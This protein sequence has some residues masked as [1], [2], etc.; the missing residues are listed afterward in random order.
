MER[1]LDFRDNLYTDKKVQYKKVMV[2]GVME[3]EAIFV[4]IFL[5]LN[6]PEIETETASSLSSE[7]RLG[8]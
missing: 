3:R 6:L 5:F 7:S 1:K 8:R 4:C 2:Y